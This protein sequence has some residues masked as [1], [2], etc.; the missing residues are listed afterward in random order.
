LLVGVC[1]VRHGIP[2]NDGD[3][4]QL[5]NAGVLLGSIVAGVAGCIVLSMARRRART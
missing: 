5:S 3:F 4:D 2:R 1:C